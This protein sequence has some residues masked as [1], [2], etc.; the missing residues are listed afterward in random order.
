MARESGQPIYG[1]YTA[2]SPQAV[3]FNT[4]MTESLLNQLDISD[5]KKADIKDFNQAVKAVK[6]QGGKPKAPNF[7]GLD[8]P[9][10]RQKLLEGPGGQR[11]AFVKAMSKAQFQKRGFPNVAAARL[12]VTEPE[13]LDVPRGSSGYTVAQLDPEATIMEQSGHKTYPL[14]IMGEYVGGLETQLP[15]EM[16]YPT[17]FEAKRLLGSTPTGAHKS[18]ELFAPLQY[19]DQQWLDN[20]MQFLEF[21]KKLQGR[22]KGGLAAVAM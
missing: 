9:E 16:M 11:D 10:I 5:L 2:M 17:H 21:Q 18:L 6:G 8:D 3:D 13:L 7:P 19:L 14:D 20:A 15:V 4:M 1:V 12:A 22:K